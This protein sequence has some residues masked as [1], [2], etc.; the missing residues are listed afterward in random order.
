MIFKILPC[1]SHGRDNVDLWYSKFSL[2]YLMVRIKLIYD[3]CLSHGRDKVDSHGGD[4]VELWWIFVVVIKWDYDIQNSPLPISRWNQV[5]LWYSKFFLIYPMVGIKWIYDMKNSPLSIP[6]W[7]LTGFMIF[8]S[9]PCLSH[10]EDKVDL[11]SY[12][13]VVIKWIHGIQI[14]SL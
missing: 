2:V 12:F 1:L 11:W 6:W 4:K 5:D 10:G 8:K 13:V 7:G 14:S 9:L 3:P